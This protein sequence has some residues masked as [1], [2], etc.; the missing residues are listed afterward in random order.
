V[1]HG[2]GSLIG[3]I[4]LLARG[5]LLAPFVRHRIVTLTTAPSRQHLDTLRAHA[6]TGH[7]TP[8][9]DRTYPLHEAPQAIRYLEGEH[10]RA[11]VVI[12]I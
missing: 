3:P 6:E 11:K 10:A 12:T 9:I 7:L 2:G 5:R 8:V 1:Y 4:W